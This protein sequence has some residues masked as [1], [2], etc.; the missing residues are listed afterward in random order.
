[1]RFW[2]VTMSL[3]PFCA[4]RSFCVRI[5]A[6]ALGVALLLASQSQAAE[7][8]P[9]RVMMLHSF[10]LQ[11]RPWTDYSKVI[12]AEISQRPSVTFQDHSLLTARMATGAPPKSSAE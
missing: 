6:A 12:R 3:R 8:T 1:M 11:F 4:R 10:G 5:V 2:L 7:T 9:K